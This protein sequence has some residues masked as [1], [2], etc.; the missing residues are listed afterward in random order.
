MTRDQRIRI[1][2]A[3][4]KGKRREDAILF[5]LQRPASINLALCHRMCGKRATFVRG[6]LTYGDKG[7]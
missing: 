2:V 6:K 1:A 4:L 5:L 7:E 3:G